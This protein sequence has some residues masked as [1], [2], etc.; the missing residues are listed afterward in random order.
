MQ[1]I[2]TV[3]GMQRSARTWIAE[4]KKIG[5]VPT[6]GA[7]HEG[8]LSLLDIIRPHCDVL[9]TSIFINP[10]QFSP[11][12]DLDRYPRDL[13]GDI[14]RLA[15]R[16]CDVVFA[17]DVDQMYPDGYKTFITVEEYDRKLCGASRPGHFRG[18]VTIVAKL[19]LITKC[20]MAV[21]GQKDYQQAMILKKMVKDLNMD[22]EV[23]V[24]P[25]VR[26]ADG[27][28]MS[29]RNAYLSPEER[30]QALVLS[31]ALNV[32]EQQVKNGI[33]R[34][35]DIREAMVNLVQRQNGAVIDYVSIVDPETLENV[36][37][38]SG[39]VVAALAVKIGEARLIDNRILNK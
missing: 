4:G 10:T 36:K 27:I 28:A 15:V 33:T 3:T 11:N 16:G 22:V 31:Q 8:H 39:P 38:I 14:E 23:M 25:I 9:V 1:I 7:L 30:K 37:I 13:E 2:E 20:H 5:L 29:S 21:F 35:A 32:A 34:A 17:P 6:M 12:E 24:A 26:E 18:V 19:F